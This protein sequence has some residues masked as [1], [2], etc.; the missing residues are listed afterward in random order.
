[1]LDI[2]V[3]KL[4]I[5]A[6][7]R[8][9]LKAEDVFFMRNILL[10][11]LHLKK[12]YKGPINVSEVKAMKTPEPL[13]NE[14]RAALKESKIIE[15]W[16]IEG[17]V[18]EVMGLLT[19]IPSVVIEKYRTLYRKNK[20]AATNYLYDLS[21]ANNYIQLNKV[22]QNISWNAKMDDGNDL[23]ITINLS[24]PEKDNKQIAKLLEEK[25]ND[26]EKYPSC[27]LCIENV[28]FGGSFEI[29]PRQNLRVIPLR[30][31]DENWFLQ[32]SP[33][34][35]YDK[36]CIV[37]FEEHKPMMISPRVFSKLFAFVD[38]YPHF[39]IGSNSDLPIVG[40]S[41]LNHEHFQGGA[42]EFP[43]FRAKRRSNFKPL[44]RKGVQISIAD[45]YNSVVVLKGKDKRRIVEIAS[46]ITEKWIN[47]NNEALDIVAMTGDV[48]H[49]T[50]TPIVRKEGPNYTMFLIL[51]NNR[52]SEQ[53]PD[54]IFHAHPEYHN[55]KKEGIGL[56]EAMGMFILPARLKRQFTLVEDIYDGKLEK[57][58]ALKENPDLAVHAPLFTYLDNDKTDL[59]VHD[60]ITNYVNDVCR[61]ILINTAV[62]KNDN[63]GQDAFQ[64]FLKT[65]KY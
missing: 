29:P 8:L 57:E 58:T 41:I 10:F 11:N 54:G 14:L 40:G 21:V 45:W 37:I 32:Y 25:Q 35:Y 44:V 23:V 27:A 62:F 49:S 16:R 65:I 38:Q 13:L 15:E 56:I 60:K 19:P 5:Y 9:G 43:L 1:M 50:V 12:P 20:V 42:A 52:T 28:G 63:D 30:L 2:I 24:K 59:K 46:K 3:E 47:Y 6:Q 55:I 18:T 34:V 53:Y 39:F 17:F 64:K 31:D 22:Q 26:D 4:L 36:H 51:R 61:N 7:N 48:R 33:Y